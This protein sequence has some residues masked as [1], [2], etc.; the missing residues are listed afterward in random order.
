[1]PV[2]GDGRYEWH[3]F[4]NGDVLP[5]SENPQQGFIT[6][7]NDMNLPPG[8]PVAERKIGFEWE[9]GARHARITQVLAQLP[10]VTLEDSQALQNDQ[11]SL[12]AQRLV[13][14]LAPLQSQDVTTAAALALLK[15]WDG[16]VAATSPAA[17]L[18]EVWFSRYLGNAYKALLLTPT[19]A[20]SCGVPDT[21]VVLNAL[22][23][24][25]SAFGQN[26]I[27]ARDQ[28]LL[29][30]LKEA[31]EAL[32]ELQGSDNS[33]WQWGK[34][35]VNAIAHP[36]SAA[37]GADRA[38]LDIGPF[39]KGGSP[40]TPNQSSYDP[41]NF[42]Q[43]NGPSARLIIDL[44]NWDNS[45]AVNYPGQSGDPAGQHY[46]DLAPLWLQG[47]YFP[48]LYTRAAIDAATEQV[49]DLVPAATR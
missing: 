13:A 28:L 5:S 15:P 6:N 38:L 3:G 36:L 43:T 19:Q 47:Q 11:V 40:Y 37:A 42:R 34:L 30:I 14:L 41:K 12:P 25:D 17:S 9:N 44:G 23:R 8:Y 21:E 16:K 49:I 32:A 46:R 33:Q 45:R 4:W 39:T 27:A 7:S 24:P 2:P 29:R 26:P 22:E 10:K 20:A 48:L 35:H 18:E 1:M 31:Y